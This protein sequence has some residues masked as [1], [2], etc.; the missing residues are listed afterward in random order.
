MISDQASNTQ[1]TA[2]RYITCLRATVKNVQTYTTS[3]HGPFSL[4]LALIHFHT[5]VL[6]FKSGWSNRNKIHV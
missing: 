2:E 3:D 5:V 4:Y 1:L 6:V